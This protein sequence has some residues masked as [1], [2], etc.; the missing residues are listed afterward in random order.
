[1]HLMAGCLFVWVRACVCWSSSFTKL[2]WVFILPNKHHMHI[3]SIPY[4]PHLKFLIRYFVFHERIRISNSCRHL[5]ISPLLLSL[6]LVLL[7]STTSQGFQ[8]CGH[9]S[10]C[11]T[12]MSTLAC[13]NVPTLWSGHILVTQRGNIV[14]GTHF[15][16][17]EFFLFCCLWFLETH[18]I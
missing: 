3:Y 14:H 9:G 11:G 5:K 10:N 16:D 17:I 7:S 12:W 18:S 2:K 4:F 13:N 8:G 1:M 6:R 15:I